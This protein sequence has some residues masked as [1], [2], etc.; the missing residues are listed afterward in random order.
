[1]FWKS[2]CSP[3]HPVIIQWSECSIV[4]SLFWNSHCFPF[5]PVIIQWSECFI[6]FHY[7]ENATALN[8]I[9]SH[10]GLNICDILERRVGLRDSIGN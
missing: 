3:C 1:L 2:H 5:R 10:I 8:S 4:F 7:F 6:V 9:Q